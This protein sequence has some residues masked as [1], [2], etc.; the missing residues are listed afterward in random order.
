MPRFFEGFLHVLQALQHEGVVAEVGLGVVVG[1]AEH[2]EQPLVQIVRPLHGVLEGVVVLGA[3][4]GLHPVEDVVPFPYVRLVQV[5]YALSCI[6]RVA[7]RH[8]TSIV[9]AWKQA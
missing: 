9:L 3:L 8:L 2:H 1:Q 7:I 5:L 4:G 6:F